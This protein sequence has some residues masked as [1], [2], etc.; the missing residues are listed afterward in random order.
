MVVCA[1]SSIMS[2]HQRVVADYRSLVVIA[3]RQ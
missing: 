2:E 1:M 3:G